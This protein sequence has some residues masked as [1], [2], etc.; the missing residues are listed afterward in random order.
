MKDFVESKQT[1]KYF[2]IEEAEK[3]LPRIEKLLKR[4]KHLD[5]AIEL[6]NTVEIEV[7]E[8]N[9]VHL[10]QV[11]KFN[12]ELH[13]L[14]YEFYKKLDEFEGTG[15]LLKDLEIGLIDFYCRFEDRDIFLCWKFGEKGIKYWHDIY[16][17]FNG[18]KQILDLINMIDKG[19]F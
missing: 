19:S 3:L 9:Y 4:L 15:C 17:G 5:K 8:E 6:L 1:K 16:T 12:K 2:T 18:R 14:Y 7:E 13:K 10:R 11:T